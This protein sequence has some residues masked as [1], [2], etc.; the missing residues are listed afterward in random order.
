M[1]ISSRQLK[2]KGL[3][4]NLPFAQS[5]NH[6]YRF[7]LNCFVALSGLCIEGVPQLPSG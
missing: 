1:Y 5:T 3:V 4:L 2:I 7:D 6:V